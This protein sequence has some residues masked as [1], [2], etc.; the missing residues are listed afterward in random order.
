MNHTVHEKLAR[1]EMAVHTARLLLRDAARTVTEH[2]ATGGEALSALVRLTGAQVSEKAVSAVD[3]VYDLAGS[4]SVY[5]TS[6]L[7][8]CFRDVHS[9]V[10]HVT[11]SQSHWEMVGHYLLGGDL[12]WRR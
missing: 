12:R 3:T 7:D 6:R 10:K 11:I 9:A 8:R 2:G 5:A 4:T 1:A